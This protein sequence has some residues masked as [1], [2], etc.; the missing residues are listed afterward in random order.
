MKEIGLEAPIFNVKLDYL[1]IEWKRGVKVG[2]ENG[3]N[4]ERREMWE[5]WTDNDYLFYG[6]LGMKGKD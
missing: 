5:D 2:R 4:Q 3:G 1:K 6:I